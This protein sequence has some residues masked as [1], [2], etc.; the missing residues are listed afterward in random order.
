[1]S[2][3]NI[4]ITDFTLAEAVSCLAIYM[5]STDGEVHDKEIKLI[6]EDP[7]LTQY[8]IIS[9]Q[10]IFSDLLDTEKLIEIMEKEM[11]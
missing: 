8:N 11:P 3:K 2:S 7:F 1:M 5:I 9:N 10:Q 6:S 4:K